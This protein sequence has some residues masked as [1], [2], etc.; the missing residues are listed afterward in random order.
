MIYPQ[1]LAIV[2]RFP[3]VVATRL[4]L[5]AALQCQVARYERSGASNHAQLDISETS[6]QW[7]AAIECIRAVS[8]RIERLVSE[9][10]IGRPSLDVALRFPNLA[11]SASASIPASLA[12]AAGRAGMDIVIS[13]Y[14]TDGPTIEVA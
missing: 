12:E 11:L 14:R 4:G 3:N 9:G 13:V 5:E 2:I 1:P 10:A 7:S 8:G 6:D